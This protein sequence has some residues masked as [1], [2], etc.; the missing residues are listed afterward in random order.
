[1]KHIKRSNI[2]RDMY[3]S[4]VCTRPKM[5]IGFRD[6]L[7]QLMHSGKEP[8]IFHC[9][10][11]LDKCCLVE[12]LCFKIIAKEIVSRMN[13]WIWIISLFYCEIG[14]DEL[15]KDIQH[16]YIFYVKVTNRSK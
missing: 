2:H 11:S 10:T 1:M 5:K 7:N 9:G 15:I 16:L 14:Q 13:I 6:E 8:G 4:P 12:L 3:V